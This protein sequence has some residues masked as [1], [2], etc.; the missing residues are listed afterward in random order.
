MPLMAKLILVRH[1]PPQIEPDVAPPRWV[2]S[3]EGRRRCAWLAGELAALGVARLYSSLEPK[4]LETA[5]LTAV[6]L[7]L[8]VGPRRDL[9]ENDRAGLAFGPLDVLKARIRRFFDEPSNLV[10]GQ[11]TAEAALRRFETAVRAL[12]AETQDRT[13]AVVTHG[14]VLTLLVA[15]RNRVEPFA[16]WEALTAPS[17]VVLDPAD[18]GLADI[19][20]YPD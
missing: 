10:M 19:R 11:E 20:K 14:T 4:A 8:E 16:F 7:G 5:A 3:A 2:L 12:A 6:R 9:H 15:R 13:A 18:F 17:L 1:A